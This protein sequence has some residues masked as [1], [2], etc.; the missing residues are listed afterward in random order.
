MALFTV[1]EHTLAAEALTTG[2]PSGQER[3][4]LSP[5]QSRRQPVRAGDTLFLRAR[6]HSRGFGLWKTNGT[7]E[8]TALLREFDAF[9]DDNGPFE[10]VGVERTV[11]FWMHEENRRDLWKSDGT[12][13]GTAR[14]TNIQPRGFQPGPS[15]LTGMNGVLYFAGTDDAGKELWRSDGTAEGTHRIKDIQPGDK[16]SDP[17]LLTA[18]NGVLFF[19]VGGSELWKSDGMEAG[20]VRVKRLAGGGNAEVAMP[21]IAGGKLFFRTGRPSAGWS[22]WSSDGTESG[23]VKLR[24]FEAGPA[25]AE[26]HAFTAVGGSVFFGVGDL[27]KGPSLWK[28]DGTMGGTIVVRTLAPGQSPLELVVLNGRL[29]FSAGRADYSMHELELRPRELWTSDG[30]RQGTSLV[31]QLATEEQAAQENDQDFRLGPLAPTGVAGNLF[32][33]SVDGSSW[34]LQKSDG[35]AKGTTD[36]GQIGPHRNEDRSPQVKTLD[37]MLFLTSGY[38]LSGYHLWRSDGT[39]TGTIP[40]TT[41]AKDGP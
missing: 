10:L 25:E 18:A 14:V 1:P 23:T 24:D 3:L 8:G 39:P 7:P 35:T 11:F 12:E 13:E 16:G 2:I 41:Y 29:F 27:G 38:G 36:L 40:V 5:V 20:T 28:S 6:S 19:F 33:I 21:T 32:F 9:P 22:L 15:R 30:T 37:A 31:M 34:N 4:W 17:R 26:P